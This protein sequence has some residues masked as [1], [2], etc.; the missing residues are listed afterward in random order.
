MVASEEGKVTAPGTPKL[1]NGI[2][3][4][5]GAL[6]FYVSFFLWRLLEFQ[7]GTSI[8][9]SGLDFAAELPVSPVAPLV[10]LTRKYY[11]D[12]M[13]CRALFRP[14]ERLRLLLGQRMYRDGGSPSRRGTVTVTAKPPSRCALVEHTVAQASESS[15]CSSWQLE[16][17]LDSESEA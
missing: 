13:N 8:S 16:L 12:A 5:Y 11:W 6:D 15:S 9:R 10:P 14:N 1:S 2:H 7:F 17:E 3:Q 4:Y